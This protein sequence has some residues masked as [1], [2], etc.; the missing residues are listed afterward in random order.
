[1]KPQ[2]FKEARYLKNNWFNEFTLGHDD[3]GYCDWIDI[4]EEK[5]GCAPGYTKHSIEYFINDWRYRGQLVPE[6]GA[7]AAFGCSYTFGYGSNLHWPGMLGVANLGQNGASNDQI[8]RLAITYCKTFKPKEIY[9]MWTFDG[10]REHILESGALVK[11]RS[12]SLEDF[13]KQK[14]VDP[15]FSAYM[16]LNNLASN[17]HN[18]NKNEMLLNSWCA[19][20]DIKIHYKDQNYFNKDDYPLAR[21]NMHPGADWHLNVSASFET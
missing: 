20:N 18:F 4:R 13:K 3:P 7:P 17:H 15:W 9:V 12:M 14:N 10:R 11:F 1:M 6:M 19:N 5:I 16:E 21:D 8:T 2:D